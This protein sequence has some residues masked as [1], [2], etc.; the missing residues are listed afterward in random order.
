MSVG[1]RDIAKA[2]G[3]S[4]ATV[5]RALRGFSTV[6]AELREHVLRV[7]GELGYVGSPAAAALSTGRMSAVGIIT[8][9]IS[10]WSFGRMLSG[11]ERELRAAGLDVLVYCVGDPSDPHPVPPLQRLRTRVDG[12]L[13]MSIAADSPDLEG[14]FG[15]D[16]PVSLIGT[17]APG[18]SCVMIDDTA[19]ARAATDH[20]LSLGHTR[21]GLIYGRENHDPLVLEHPR[22]LGYL[23]ALREAGL[24][25]DPTLELPGQFSVPGGEQAM[26][27]LLELDDP[28][29]AVFAMSDEMA[30]GAMRALWDSG[31][32]PGPDMALIGFDGHDMAD[33]FSLSTVVQPLEELGRYGARSIVNALANPAQPPELT[34]LPTELVVRAS[35][36]GPKP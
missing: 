6:D 11:V 36:T 15:L 23:E 30:F 27:Q 4:T 34:V 32:E 5:S 8:P 9:Y 3:V 17:S 12:F 10:R 24:E 31:R 18:V 29:T 14:L 28:P 26:R 2:A 16:I 33:V 1:I 19:G 35:S 20:L 21:I 25:P 13:V 7:A 22:Y